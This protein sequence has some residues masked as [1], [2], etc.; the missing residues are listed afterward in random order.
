MLQA[1]TATIDITPPPGSLMAC[2]PRAPNREPRRAKGAHDPLQAKVLVLRD[3]QIAL[4][5]PKDTVFAELTEKQ[6]AMSTAPVGITAP[7]KVS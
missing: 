6:A 3:G 2:F 7:G 4:F 1:G 5:G